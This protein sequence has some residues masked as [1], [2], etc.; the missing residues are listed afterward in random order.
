MRFRRA[1]PQAT[2]ATP[3]TARARA[4]PAGHPLPN[5]RP[6][7]ARRNA[8]P[9]RKSGLDGRRPAAQPS[10]RPPTDPRWPPLRG[11]ADAAGRRGR[12]HARPT[13]LQ[14]VP[15]PNRGR[16]NAN[17]RAGSTAGLA[18]GRALRSAR[19]RPRDSCACWPRTPA[20]PGRCRARP[21][22]IFRALRRATRPACWARPVRP[23]NSQRPASFGGRLRAAHQ[24]TTPPARAASRCAAASAIPHA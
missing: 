17:S 13:R 18:R 24:S 11:R 7:Q 4:S 15:A 3:P 14:P 12:W 22:S 2:A 10:S 8:S 1:P 19:A 16:T 20:H 9:R 5:A 21:C 6:R 23:R